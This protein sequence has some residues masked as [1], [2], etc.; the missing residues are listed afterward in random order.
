MVRYLHFNHKRDAYA[1]NVGRV[2]R[3]KCFYHQNQ[4]G[5]A[6]LRNTPAYI[7]SRVHRLEACATIHYQ[8]H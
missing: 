3:A 7:M 8:I 6:H 1:T 2:L 4:V 5:S